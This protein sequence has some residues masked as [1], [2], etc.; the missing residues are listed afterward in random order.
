[1]TAAFLS[2]TR[3]LRPEQAALFHL[4]TD[5][6]PETAGDRQVQASKHLAATFR[7]RE[8][9]VARSTCAPHPPVPQKT[10]RRSHRRAITKPTD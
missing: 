9:S 3:R 6:F 5:A 7:A 10:C 8:G 4:P 1:M 2:A